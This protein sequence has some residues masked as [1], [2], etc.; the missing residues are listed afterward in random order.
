ML[1]NSTFFIQKAQSYIKELQ[2][3]KSNLITD[4]KDTKYLQEQSKIIDYKFKVKLLF[5]EFDKGSLFVERCI[6]IDT[7]KQLR[8]KNSEVIDDISRH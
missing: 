7:N 5:T 6:N 1:K 3:L 8:G 4:V 2:K